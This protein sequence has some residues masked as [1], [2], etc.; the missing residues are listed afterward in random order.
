M[1][2]NPFRTAVP[3]WGQTTCSLSALSP[4][5]GTAVLKGGNVFFVTL[6]FFS[7]AAFFVYACRLVPS[8][9]LVEYQVPY[10]I[11]LWEG[12][13]KKCIESSSWYLNGLCASAQR[14]KYG[15]KPVRAGASR[16]HLSDHS[17]ARSRVVR[18]IVEGSSLPSRSGVRG[19]RGRGC[20]APRA[21][22]LLQGTIVNRT[23]YCW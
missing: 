20:P 5:N 3:F 15:G 12:N 22:R 13:F 19:G 14:G 18:L 17:S 4:H 6:L 8:A 1:C 16:T 7:S 21:P 9:V 10:P 2:F 23:N 11:L